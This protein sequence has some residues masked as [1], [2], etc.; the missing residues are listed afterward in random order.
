LRFM[1]A[2]PTASLYNDR[3]QLLAAIEFACLDLLG[4]HTG[5]PVHALLGGAVREELEF[6]SYL[7]FRYP[8]TDGNSEIRTPEELVE[9]ARQLKDEHGFRVHKLKGGVFEPDYELECYR[10]LAEALPGDRL[11]YDPN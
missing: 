11:R 7:F 4:Q 5:L 10:A 3:T 8:S 2:N 1:I 9:H 6:A